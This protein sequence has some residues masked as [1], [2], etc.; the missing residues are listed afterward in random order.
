VSL[1]DKLAIWSLIVG[2]LGLLVTIVGFW[3]A[4]SQLRRTASA[5]EATRSAIEASTKRMRL[6]HLLVLL[7]QFR[8]FEIDLDNAGDDNDEKAARRALVGYSHTANQVAELLK[9]E[10]GIEPD[11]LELLRSSAI[12]A[13]SAKGRLA[14]GHETNVRAVVEEISTQVSD[15]SA[16][17]A[18]II[19]QYQ[20]QVA[21]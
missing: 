12:S 11:F 3:L 17:A 1:S 10:E 15:V 6:N 20:T 9:G 13:A 7:P 19:T 18:G 21:A 8:S 14:T 2:I 16:R 5:T 4:V